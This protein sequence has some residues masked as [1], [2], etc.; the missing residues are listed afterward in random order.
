MGIRSSVYYVL[1]KRAPSPVSSPLEWCR[2]PLSCPL[3]GW[4][5][6]TVLPHLPRISHSLCSIRVSNLSQVHHR[7][8]PSLMRPW[9]SPSMLPA[10][11]P[12]TLPAFMLTES[13]SSK[14]ICTWVMSLPSGFFW[15][16]PWSSLSR[17]GFAYLH[18]PVSLRLATD[19]FCFHTVLSQD[20]S[21]QWLFIFLS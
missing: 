13:S 4:L 10:W 7:S 8:P 2:G 9:V 6:P 12:I 5:S 15:L 3:Q 21:F 18:S 1:G 19:G 16:C 20:P 17:S 14:S 11:V